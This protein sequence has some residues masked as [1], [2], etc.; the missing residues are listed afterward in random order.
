V[1]EKPEKT[2]W[3]G[4]ESKSGGLVS[5]WGR[6][7]GGVGRKL[8]VDG[9]K[10][11]KRERKKEKYMAGGEKEVEVGPPRTRRRSKDEKKR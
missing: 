6:R 9:K 4:E 11:G 5:R 10:R 3:M 1:R 2:V 8:R 7:R